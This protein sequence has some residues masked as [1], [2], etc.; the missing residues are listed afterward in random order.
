MLPLV[1]LLIACSGSQD[2]EDTEVS[3]PI[4][5]GPLPGGMPRALEILTRA[6][7]A[8]LNTAG[9]GYLAYIP[10]GGLPSAAVADYLAGSFNR[11]TG[12]TA[13]AH[14]A[15]VLVHEAQA[16]HLVAEIGNAASAIGRDRVAKIMRD[17]PSYHTTP[18]EAAE[19]ANAAGVRLLVLTHLN[20]PPP[21]RIA[22]A[23]LAGMPLAAIAEAIREA[24]A[25]RLTHYS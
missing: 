16:N 7:G 5:E 6:V 24:S 14:G 8:S 15:D 19:I 11:F 12:L 22:P 20:P 3:T 25:A 10:G 9:P 17:I 18:V 13:A 1:A 21:N 4:P 2:T 23:Q